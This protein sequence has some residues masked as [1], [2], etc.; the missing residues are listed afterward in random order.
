MKRFRFTLEAL[1][2]LR[3]RE[4]EE[5]RREFAE[6]NREI[7]LSQE[8]MGQLRESLVQLQQSEKDRRVRSLSIPELRSSVSYRNKIKLDMI[9]ASKDL[10]ELQRECESIRKRLVEATKRKRAVEI[11]KERRFAQWKEAYEAQEQEFTDEL[12]QKSFSRKA[13]PLSGASR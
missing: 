7:A 12:S 10:Q 6:K 2:S 4:E 13:P 9:T 3:K 11:L 8:N 1:L 5:V